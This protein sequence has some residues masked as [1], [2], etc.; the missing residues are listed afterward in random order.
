MILKVIV[1]VAFLVLAGCSTTGTS[2]NKTLAKL[3]LP[4]IKSYLN[5]NGCNEILSISN[6]GALPDGD[7]F[8]KKL[9]KEHWRVEGCGKTYNLELAASKDGKHVSIQKL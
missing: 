9:S 5:K 2:D 3:S 1:Y 4:L 8:G 7:Y 6:I